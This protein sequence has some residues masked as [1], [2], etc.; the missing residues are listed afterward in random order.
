[1]VA[2]SFIGFMLMFISIGLLSRIQRKGT[3]SDYLLASQS[4]KP[5]LVALSAVATN[6]SGYMFVGMIGYTYVAGL[7]SM[8]LMIGWIFGDFVASLFIHKRIR[9]VSEQREVL[10]FS[11]TLSN[12]HGESNN[13]LRFIS[14]LITIAFL[15]TYAAAQLKAGSKALYILFGWDYSIGAIVGVVI[16]LLYCF[17][18]GIRASIWTNTAQSF[19]MF[20]A[21]GLLLITAVSSVGG[22][23]SFVT[24]LE[25]ISPTYLSVFPTDLQFGATGI[26]L[27][28]IGWIFAGFGVVGQPHIMLSFMTMDKASDISRVRLY[29]YSWYVSFSA[30][31]IMS[32]LAAR[33]LI[34]EM[35]SFDPEL[36]LPTLAYSL[37]PEILV[38]LVLAGMFASTMSTA[39]SQILACTASATR[40]LTGGRT[41]SVRVTKFATIGVAMIALSIALLG[42][43]SVFFLV[44]VAWS[45]LGASF[46]PLLTLYTIGKR[47]TENQA[48]IIVLTGF[49]MMLFWQISGLNYFIHEIAAGILAGF[50]AYPITNMFVNKESK[51]KVAESST[52][53]AH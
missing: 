28:I 14:G 10:S 7:S 21:M 45:V 31:A 53:G 51:P 37:L 27:F 19:V 35:N 6:N 29:Y 43:D 36:A 48:I 16:V 44:V 18:G 42:N 39:D 8:W 3:A 20:F 38:G 15:G 32:G 52:E 13:R 33:L 23:G 26:T 49:S 1:M 5:W 17:A 47:T 11:G 34:P 25:A 4:I 9:A 30:M 2:I 22:W 46:A 40:D 50:L 41:V 24:Q 12:W